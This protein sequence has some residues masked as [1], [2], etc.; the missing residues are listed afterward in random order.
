MFKDLLNKNMPAFYHLLD[1]YINQ[2]YGYNFDDVRTFINDNKLINESDIYIANID[3]N[4]KS[5]R[6]NP[7]KYLELNYIIANESLLEY[8]SFG[9]SGIKSIQLRNL[10]YRGFDPE[11]ISDEDFMKHFKFCIINFSNNMHATSILIYIID[12]KINVLAINSGKGIELHDTKENKYKPYIALSYQKKDYTKVIDLLLFP[13]FYSKFNNTEIEQYNEDL[14]LLCQ[15]NFKLLYDNFDFNININNVNTQFKNYTVKRYDKILIEDLYY[16]ILVDLFTNI[17]TKTLLKIHPR[18][19]LQNFIIDDTD[20]KYLNILQK[21]KFHIID[22]DIY[23]HDQQSGSCTWFSKYWALCL[24]Y[25]INNNPT[26]YKLFIF[27]TLETSIKI[28]KS[29][30]TNENFNLEFEYINS[31]IIPMKNIFTKLINLDLFTNDELKMIKCNHNIYDYTIKIEELDNDSITDFTVSKYFSSIINIKKTLYD[32]LILLF[33]NN[34]DKIRNRNNF[35]YYVCDHINKSTDTYF[36]NIDH[37]FESDNLKSDFFLENIISNI[38]SRIKDKYV[39]DFNKL[40]DE[41]TTMDIEIKYKTDILKYIDNMRRFNFGNIENNRYEILLKKLFKIKDDDKIYSDQIY[42]Y[43]IIT[44]YLNLDNKNI[45]RCINELN[46]ILILVEILDILYSKFYNIEEYFITNVSEEY[47]SNHRSKIIDKE[48]EKYAKE[49]DLINDKLKQICDSFNQVFKSEL[50]TNI[51][52]NIIKNSNI[53]RD[54]LVKQNIIKSILQDIISIEYYEDQNIYKYIFENN[55][56]LDRLNYNHDDFKFNIDYLANETNLLLNNP[57]L[58]FNKW[59]DSN[60]ISDH[61]F[62]F[63]KMNINK[64]HKNQELKKNLLKYFLKLFLDNYNKNNHITFFCIINIQL[65]LFKCHSD[66]DMWISEYFDYNLRRNFRDYFNYQIKIPFINFDILYEILIYNLIT[67]KKDLDMTIE[68]LYDD[69][70]KPEIKISILLERHKI[71]KN[72]YKII[73]LDK[74][75]K[76][77]LNITP[78]YIQY[79]VKSDSINKNNYIYILS[80]TNYIIIEFDID[81]KIINIF[82]NNDKKIPCIKNIEDIH[83]PFKYMIPLNCFHLITEING[84]YSIIY[85]MNTNYDL[86][87]THNI[88]NNISYNNHIEIVNISKNNNFLPISNISNFVTILENYGYNLLN[89]IYITDKSSNG[90]QITEYECKLLKAKIDKSLYTNKLNTTKNNNFKIAN[91]IYNNQDIELKNE[92]NILTIIKKSKDEIVK[93]LYKLYKKIIKCDSL[94]IGKIKQKI[95]ILKLN[96]ENNILIINKK[97]GKLKTWDN[98]INELDLLL[99]YID[100]NKIIEILNELYNTD[101]SN[102]CNQIKIYINLF[103]N[104]KYYLEYVFEYLFE[105]IYGYE[106]L[107]E[108]FE[109]YKNILQEFINFSDTNAYNKPISNSLIDINYNFKQIG[110]DTFKTQFTKDIYPIPI[111]HFMMGKGKSAVITPLLALYFSL[112]HDKKIYII[113][114]Q[115]LKKQTLAT[116]NHYAYFFQLNEKI[117]VLSDSEIKIAYL[118]DKASDEQKK[119]ILSKEKIE[120]IYKTKES[121]LID[122]NSIMLIDEFDTVIDP[123]ISNLNIKLEIGNSVL[124]NSQNYYQLLNNIIEDIQD[125]KIKQKIKSKI[126][127]IKQNENINSEIKYIREQLK[128]NNLK[129]NINWGIHPTKAYIIPYFGKDKAEI[130]STFSSIILTMYLT[131][132]YYIIIKDMKITQNIKT[133]IIDNNL[134]NKILN[135]VKTNT[136]ITDEELVKFYDDY[137]FNIMEEILNKIFLTVIQLN[138]SF[139][140]ILYIENIYKIGYSGTLNINYP[141]FYIQD[142]LKDVFNK[143]EDYDVALNITYAIINESSIIS[144]KIPNTDK[145]ILTCKDFITNI[146]LF[147]NYDVFIDTCGLFKNIENI[148]IAKI[149]YENF[150]RPVIFITEIDD[151]RIFINN[152]NISYNEFYI[153]DVTPIIYYDQS[154]TVGIDINQNKFPSLKGLCLIDNLNKYKE[155]A[156]AM[157]RLRKLNM[158]HI[159]DFLR[160]CDDKNDIDNE[161][162]INIFFENDN[163]DR[164]N[165]DILLN[166][167]TYKSINRNISPIKTHP[168]EEKVKYYFNYETI[169]DIQILLQD[170]IH[171]DNKLLS[172]LDLNDREL[173]FKL[174]CNINSNSFSYDLEHKQEEEQSKKK[175]IQIIN[176]KEIIKLESLKSRIKPLYVSIKYDSNFDYTN[177]AIKYTDDISFLPNIFT[178]ILTG[179]AFIVINKKLLLIPGHM[180]KVFLKTSYP[181]LSL[182]R[183]NIRTDIMYNETL[184]FDDIILDVIDYKYQIEN[185]MDKNDLS[186]LLIIYI[187]INMFNNCNDYQINT[188]SKLLTNFIQN[189]TFKTIYKQLQ[190]TYV[191]NDIYCKLNYYYNK[192]GSIFYEYQHVPTMTDIHRIKYLKYKAKYLKYK[193]INN[194]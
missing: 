149:L 98:I 49:T 59:L 94:N 184:D 55:M 179:L 5:Y 133:Y 10:T 30:F 50:L 143:Y 186:K 86:P 47:Q 116:L 131:L 35:Y 159:V 157:F 64:I 160:I 107:D 62:L 4:S 22:D 33:T 88:L 48:I 91:E 126:P 15:D 134:F 109:K 156:Q 138:T 162:L 96:Y 6:S 51:L 93:S 170:I 123:T 79:L 80:Y 171:Y 97:L 187:L 127:I 110:G 188:L 26:K 70:I 7:N 130:N 99:N 2:N 84:M 161:K 83:C 192:S 40:Y 31:N 121:V 36:N 117:I 41:I 158:G 103:D 52:S 57:S 125:I 60:K 193:K 67:C 129:E 146:H 128:N 8:R 136:S 12:D 20:H 120:Q 87:D 114:P 68:Y 81:G 172:K 74:K 173:L 56:I 185:V 32:L 176:E 37:I 118:Y 141:K 1:G 90:Y 111:H 106:I 155:I 181:I 189:N 63:I 115:H 46:R 165:K 183:K 124:D 152:Q 16:N 137:F 78:D 18:I 23:I 119:L 89:G 72:D 3:I 142:N 151:K 39:Q 85:F 19:N 61:N 71:E 182:S 43:Y 147:S 11:Y 82:Y 104:R 177:I 27:N 66:T 174:I 42:L 140:D 100:N 24:Y 190:Q 73:N 144:N 180:I 175:E 102:L 14:Y 54:L 53:M 34:E 45:I 150:K 135:T 194:I 108:Q 169:P 178:P 28:V 69:L 148:N 167:Q 101:E 105:F 168:N 77:M 92:Q 9:R 122:K 113:V 139:V 75:I 164:D 191:E 25:V 17:G 58:I 21:T 154:H 29:I 76:N 112:I 132:Y 38:I 166:F 13:L 65:L 163:K 44:Y 153:F 145:L 95:E